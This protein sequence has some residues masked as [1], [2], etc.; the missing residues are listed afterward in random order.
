MRGLPGNRPQVTQRSLLGERQT[1]AYPPEFGEGSSAQPTP[2]HPHPP[3]GRIA[4]NPS[5]GGEGWGEGSSGQPPSGYAKVSLRE[6]VGM[7]VAAG[8]STHAQPAATNAPNQSPAVRI[9]SGRRGRFQTGRFRATTARGTKACGPGC[10][11]PGTSPTHPGSP[12]RHPGVPGRDPAATHPKSAPKPPLAPNPDQSLPTS[13]H[14]VR[15][16]PARSPRSA[17]SN[18]PR[19]Q[20]S[21]SPASAIPA[22]PAGTQHHGQPRHSQATPGAPLPP[23]LQAPPIPSP[24]QSCARPASQTRPSSGRD[25]P[26]P[27][28]PRA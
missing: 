6:K 4:L 27:L 10:A 22:S 15:G 24:S 5:P 13:A 3:Q 11:Q 14:P 2:T 12:L 17:V 8:A 9:P 25:A 23:A 1:P 7:R 28:P 18:H 19:Q 26:P 20:P 16:E 21:P